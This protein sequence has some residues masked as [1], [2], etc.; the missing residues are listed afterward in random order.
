MPFGG[1][2]GSG[3]LPC[4][5]ARMT[6]F[7]TGIAV[8]EVVAL[9]RLL[10]RLPIHTPTTTLLVKP[11]VHRSVLSLVVPVLAATIPGYSGSARPLFKP[12]AAARAALSLRMIC[13]R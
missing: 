12:K 13:I 11:I 10:F 4:R 7:H 6:A 2:N 3:A 9:V 1:V 8:F 5:A